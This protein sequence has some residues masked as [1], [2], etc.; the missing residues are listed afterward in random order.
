MSVKLLDILIVNFC[1][2]NNF[3]LTREY[4]FDNSRKWRSDYYIPKLNLLIEYEGLGVG[5]N[6]T[7]SGGHQ[8]VKGYTGNCE[9]YN[10]ASLLGYRLLRYTALNYGSIVSDL[11]F[12]L[13]L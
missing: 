8:T 4:Q 9:K 3:E 2:T 11:E 12:L 7:R 1:K 13:S 5:R 10:K 6:K